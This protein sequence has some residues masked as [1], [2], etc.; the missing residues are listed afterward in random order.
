MTDQ[1]TLNIILKCI[2]GCTTFEQLK[3]LSKVHR[4]NR[5]V[6][7]AINERACQLLD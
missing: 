2:K 6:E 7:A 5:E 4:G 1:E 3:V